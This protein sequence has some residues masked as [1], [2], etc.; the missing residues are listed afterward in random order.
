MCTLSVLRR[1]GSADDREPPLWRVSFNRDERRTRPPALPP[2]QHIYDNRAA[3][4]PLDPLGGGTWIAVSSAGLVFALLNGYS[5]GDARPQAAPAAKS[6]GLIIPALLSADTLD[7][8][9][10]RVQA[11]DPS[12]FLSFRLV[13]VADHGALEAV[14]D[15]QRLECDVVAEGAAWMRS[16]S[17]ARPEDV[18]PH[19]RAMFQEDVAPSLRA[20]AQDRF[21]LTRHATDPALG[22][23]M[24]RDDART[25]SVTTVEVFATHARMTYRAL[26][27]G[28]AIP[29]PA[30]AIDIARQRD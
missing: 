21:H 6:R 25:V 14:S 1:P 7:A 5:D 3:V 12:A 24:Q 30:A 19:R 20:A 2:Q 17:S 16:S 10:T 11:I 15:G 9:T 22:V 29:E 26:Q 8:A 18:L 4:Y 13:I 27:P 28:A 23:L